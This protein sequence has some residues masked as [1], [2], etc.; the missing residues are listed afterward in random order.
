MSSFFLSAKVSGSNLKY[1]SSGTVSVWR[2]LLL[3]S[4]GSKCPICWCKIQT[5]TYHW[6]W[7]IP[8][9]TKCY[10]TSD[11]HINHRQ[12]WYLKKKRKEN[13]N[14]LSLT[15]HLL[16]F[17]KIALRAGRKRN[18]CGEWWEPVIWSEKHFNKLYGFWRGVLT[19][20]WLIYCVYK[21][22]INR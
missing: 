17:L 1:D 22:E 21:A 2:E 10:K 3:G 7:H 8:S 18:R 4:R 16:E 6:H 12:C 15:T 11:I 20:Y 13:E 19:P 9:Q 5:L 14:N